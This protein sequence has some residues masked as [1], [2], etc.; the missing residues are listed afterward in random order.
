MEADQKISETAAGSACDWSIIRMKDSDWLI[1]NPNL[2][3]APLAVLLGEGVDHRD[4]LT[5]SHDPREKSP[6]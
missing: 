5:V 4:V 6:T 3:S 1:L 2:E